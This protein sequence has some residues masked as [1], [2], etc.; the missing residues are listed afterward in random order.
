MVLTLPYKL[1]ASSL[2]ETIVA[3][4][5]MVFVF[6]YSVMIINNV[7]QNA[8]LGAKTKVTIEMY[9]LLEE[10]KQ[11]K[12]LEDE[13]IHYLGYTIEK[14]VE[15]SKEDQSVYVLHFELKDTQG[16][17]VDEIKEQVLVNEK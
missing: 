16:N 4:V 6:V 12:T 17:V 2:L 13:L 3:M 7:M 15:V 9:R 10:T 5:I 11:K 1:K 8:Y 14:T